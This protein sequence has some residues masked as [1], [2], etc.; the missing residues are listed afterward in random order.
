MSEGL[1]RK[2]SLD[3]ISSPEQINDYIRTS[4]L[5]I[6]VIF[7]A[8]ALLL[9]G[10]TVWGV[11]GTIDISVSSVAVC[12]NGNVTCYI[13][14]SDI[15]EISDTA[16]AR[17]NGESYA[18]TDVSELP[19]PAKN[20]LSPYGLHLAGF[21]DDE[22]IYLSSVSADIKDGMYKAA[23]IIESV[24]PISLLMN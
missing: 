4:N 11:F 22:W 16:R 2:N 21:D 5:S 8:A 10:V 23:I 19:V 3:K 24:S 6:W 15:E 18:L 9:I 1:F 20:T 14:E 13:S 17:I 12:E 7:I